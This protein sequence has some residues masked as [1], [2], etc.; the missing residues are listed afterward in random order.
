M[1][2][3]EGMALYRAGLAAGSAASG[4]SSSR[5]LLREVSGIPGGG[6]RETGKCCSAS[7]ITTGSEGS[8]NRGGPTTTLRVVDQADGGDGYVAW[9]RHTVRQAGLEGERGPGRGR[10]AHGGPALGRPP[11]RWCFIDGGHGEE[12]G[13]GRLPAWVQKV[14]EADPGHPRRICRPDQG[15]Q[16][17]FA[18]AA[19]RE[20]ARRRDGVAVVGRRGAA[21][22]GSADGRQPSAPAPPGAGPSLT[23]RPSAARLDAHMTAG[24]SPSP[25]RPP[26]QL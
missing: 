6:S 8:C 17:P 1:P 14:A 7:T 11:W 26:T 2:D 22:A 16:V 13:Q 23:R 3:H 12:V 20:S 10:V 25:P 15:G 18:T 24:P 21:T 4:R 5:H 19:R 9:A